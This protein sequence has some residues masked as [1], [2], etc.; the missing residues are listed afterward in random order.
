MYIAEPSKD[1]LQIPAHGTIAD[2]ILD[3]DAFVRTL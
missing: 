1:F 2:S 3:W